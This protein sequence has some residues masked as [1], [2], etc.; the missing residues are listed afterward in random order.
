MSSSANITSIDCLRVRLPFNHGGPAPLFA[1]KPRATLDTVWVRVQLANGHVG[2]GEAYAADVD[3]VVSILQNRVAPL[4]VGRDASDLQL[5]PTLERTL[6]NMG[7][8]GPVLH[9]L[10]GLDI[11][12]WDLRA[13]LAGV[14]LYELLGGA[15]RKR[16]PAYASLLQYNGDADLVRQATARALATGYTQVKLHERT[17]ATVLA[18]RAEAGRDVQLMLDTN[19]AWDLEGATAALGQMREADL[20]WIEEPLWPPED[21]DGLRQLRDRTGVPTAVGENAGSLH[22]LLAIVRTAAAGWVQ[23]SALKCGGVTA[24]QR[25]AEACR[26]SG[27]RLSPHCAFFGPSF[28]ATLHVLAAYEPEV[29]VERIFV[30]LAHVPYARSVPFERGA[31]VL[32]DAPGLGA[33]PEP[34]LLVS[35]Y[36]S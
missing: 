22:D 4:A 34:S 19:C 10:S 35:P 17:A 30:D 31:F 6:H 18:A 9:A 28:L 27:V 23:P 3:A 1:G 32:N 26:D 33:N 29:V 25:V 15:R 2:W 5:S 24:L 20:Y 8:S 21:L 11:A 36:V 16:I 12:L 13:K 14:P 7:R